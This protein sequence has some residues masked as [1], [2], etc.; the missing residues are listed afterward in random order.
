MNSSPSLRSLR[1]QRQ[2]NRYWGILTGP[3]MEPLNREVKHAIG[4]M[5]GALLQKGVKIERIDDLQRLPAP[6]AT[7]GVGEIIKKFSMWAV[8]GGNDQREPFDLF[9]MTSRGFFW[10]H[11]PTG[12]ILQATPFDQPQIS[13]HIKSMYEEMY[14]DLFK[15]PKFEDPTFHE[16]NVKILRRFQLNCLLNMMIQDLHHILKKHPDPAHLPIPAFL[17]SLLNNLHR[18]ASS[19]SKGTK[20][21]AQIQAYLN[22]Q[23]PEAV[24]NVQTFFAGHKH[25][26]KSSLFYAHVPM[27]Q[28]DSTTI[29]PKFMQEQEQCVASLGMIFPHF[30]GQH[31]LLFIKKES[32]NTAR[33]MPLQVV[34]SGAWT[35]GFKIQYSIIC[36]Q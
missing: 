1:Q 11:L 25:Q 15:Q 13:L 16:S 31:F 35:H 9:L 8:K 22:S 30:F 28:P 7:D 4:I 23:Q 29:H 19:S 5:L 10:L 24:M 14:Q 2:M 34:R 33:E 20:S 18:Y 17:K 3:L 36:R 21:L 12:A 26:F 27:E 32:E 6:L